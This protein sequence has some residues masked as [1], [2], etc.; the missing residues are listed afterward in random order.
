VQP[1]ITFVDD[2]AQLAAAVEMVHDEIVGVDVERADSDRYHRRAALVQ[3]GDADTCLLLDPLEIPEPTALVPMFTQRLVVLHAIENDIAPLDA[4][5]LTPTSAADTGIAAAL[6][7][8]PT[9]LTSLLEEV[10]GVE[11]DTDKDKYQRAD[12]EQRPLS[13]G[14]IDYAAGDVLHLPALWRELAT[15]LATADRTDWYD[16]ELVATIDQARRD[17]RDWTRT[18]GAGRLDPDARA[19]LRA[20]WE[21]REEICAT[22]D[23]APNRLLHDRTLVALA[24]D[25]ADA[26][27]DLV[28]RNQRRP[29]VLRD[30][31]EALFAAQQ[32]GLESEPEPLEESRRFGDAERTAFDRLRNRRSR[33]AAELGID[34]GVLCPSRMLRD[35]VAGAPTSDLAF[36]EAAGLRA[37]QREVLLEELWAAYV[38]AMAT[39]DD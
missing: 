35:A 8:L 23:I 37:W 34:A 26:P 28:R 17:T 12:W 13:Q 27:G 9:G 10:L 1:T 36:A 21:T 25:P 24:A 20:L 3:V 32:R 5:G 31:V 29:D 2:E 15:R 18:K 7:G 14:M 38:G 19:V 33:L 22:Q 30:H 39:D 16:Q 11:L 6:L 4:L